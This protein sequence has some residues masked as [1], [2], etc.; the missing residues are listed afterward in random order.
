MKNFSITITLFLV[1]LSASINSVFCQHWDGESGLETN[2]W[3]YGKVGIGTEN[4]LQS[5]H[6]LDTL[7]I[8]PFSISG[9]HQGA[10]L[11]LTSLNP[12][13]TIE[14]GFEYTNYSWD[15]RAF[16]NRLN[17]DYLKS[18]ISNN[19]VNTPLTIEGN[20]NLIINGKSLYK[21][22]TSNEDRSLP[23]GTKFR[24]SNLVLNTPVLG[25]IGDD[26]PMF[27]DQ[28]HHWD[29]RARGSTLNIDY[30]KEIPSVPSFSKTIFTIK[31]EKIGI[32]TQDPQ[33]KLAVN[34]RITAKEVEVTLIG[35]SDFVFD[36]DYRLMPIEELETFI[37][38][39]KHLPD[40]P[41][42]QEVK[43]KGVNL[44]QMDA[45]LLQKIEELTLY[46]IELKKENDRLV[47]KIETIKGNQH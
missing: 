28:Q 29:F 27:I 6:I 22:F 44:G 5:I 18:Q 25:V 42:E 15:I 40:V 19:I 39:N 47:K 31:N 2:I 10:K 41:S 23:G 4:P 8:L 3:R 1:T 33:S 17:L 35:W 36:N 34:G 32:G 7:E 26:V 38:N 13:I 46:I 30:I 11:R 14:N 9:S 45:I 24:I 12:E 16:E 20:G 43:E 37:I 21:Q